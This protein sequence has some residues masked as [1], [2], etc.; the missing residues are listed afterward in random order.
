MPDI[1]A[2]LFGIQ[3]AV[4]KAF[5]YA[6]AEQYGLVGITGALCLAGDFFLFFISKMP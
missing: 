2:Q 1:Q 4:M 6:M 5:F 3:Y